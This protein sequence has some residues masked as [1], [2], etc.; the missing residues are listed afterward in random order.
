M[1][2]E[3]KLREYLKRVT[4]DLRRTR[5]RLRD[6]EDEAH[7]PIA[8]VGMACRF[9]GGITSPEALWDLVAASGDAIGGFPTDRGWDLTDLYDPTR[10]RPGTS[11][12]RE[13][14]FVHDAADFDPRFFGISPREALA[15]DPQQR[16]LL[17]VSWEAFESA[18]VDPTGFR[19]GPV[20][21]FAG[22][23]HGGYAT[24]ATDVPD[25]AVDYLGLGNA[26]SISS[27]RVAYSFGFEGPAVTVDTACSSSLVALHLAAQSLRSGECDLALAGGV[28]VLSTPAIFVDF[29]RQGNL[30]M[31]ARCRAFAEAADG[32]A[33]AEGIGVLLVERL[34][35]ARRLGHRVL[36]V[37]RG[38]A[39]NQDG[40]SNGLTA[41]NGPSQ[42]RVIRQA[43]ASARLST[44]DVDVLE[45]HGTG[46]TLGDPI[47]AQALLATYGQGRDGHEPLLLGSVK[48]N[49]GHTQSAA[50]VAGVIKM[51]Q[52][53]R[54]G[55]VPATLHVDEP[56][57]KVDWSAG[58]VTLVTRARQW[59]AVDRPRRAAVSSFGISGTNAHIIIEQPQPQ[60]QPIAGQP[61]VGTA[62]A[63]AAATGLP[64]AADGGQPASVFASVDAPAVG[65]VPGG[66]SRTDDPD[67][68][69]PWLVSG[70]SAEGL[71]GQAAR[72]AEFARR[73]TGTS[74]VEIGWSLATARAALDHRAVLIGTDRDALVATVDALAAG[75]VEQTSAPS[76]PTAGTTLA[77]GQA[78]PGRRALLFAGQGSQRPGMGRELY[79]RFPVFADV[80]DRV[81]G[82]FDGRLDHP[83]REVVFAE[84]G[85]ELAGLLDETAFTQAGLFA[86]EVAL[87]ELLSSFGV[88]A[89]VVAGHSVGEVTAAHVAGVL[90]LEDACAL[91]VARG[92]L[93]QALPP[94]GGMLAVAASEAEIREIVDVDVDAGGVG[95]DVAAV[96][97]PRSVVVSGPVVELDDI[98]QRCVGRG[99]R[100]KRLSVSHA[101]HSRLMEPMLDEFRA[102]L[103]DLEWSSPQLPVV[104]NVSGGI[105][106][107]A[108]ITDP[109]YWVRHVREAVRFGD[110]VAALLEAGVSTFVEVGPDATL[111][112]LAAETSGDRPVHLVAALRRDQSETVGVLTALAR[113]HVTGTS[114]DWASWFTRAG[115]RPR[116]V[117]LPT[118]AFQHQ[119][120][121][122]DAGSSGADATGLGVRGTTH[123]LLDAELVTAAGDVRIHG[124]RLSVR[125]RPWLADHMVWGA[126]VVPGAA[127]VEMALHAGAQA[128]C[129]SLEELTLAAPLVLPEQGARAVQLILAAPDEHGR[130]QLSVHSRPAD[131]P[132][133]EWTRHAEGVLAPG[134]VDPAEPLTTWPPTGA[135]AVPVAPI[136]EHLH[137][138]GVDH[139]P[140]FRGLRA[141]WR[142]DD[143]VY[144]E[145]ALPDGVTPGGFGL[146]P[147][148]LDAA[149]HVV[150]LTDDT[151]TPTPGARLPFAWS[152]VTLAAVGATLLRVR[153][154]R[155]GPAVSLTLADGTG[156]TVAR[157]GS[158]VSR[159][160]SAEQL[161]ATD[162]AE[163][164][165]FDLRW[166]P[167]PLPSRPAVGIVALD[168][169]GL[170]AT[171]LTGGLAALAHALDAGRHDP[172]LVLLPA[173]EAPPGDPLDAT[174]DRLA[175]TLTAVREWLAD[176][177]F[178]DRRLVVFTRGAVGADGAVTDLA[179][180]AVWGLVRSA[181]L[182]HP[183]RFVLVDLDDQADADLL[184]RALASDEPQLALRDGR[185]LVPR[186]APAEPDPT[187]AVDLLPD[188]TVLVT[189]ATGTLGGHVARHLVAAHKVRHLLLVGRRGQDAP[190]AADLLDDLTRLGA[191][192]RFVACDV[193][194]R[195]QVA[196]LLDAVPADHPLT[197]VVHAAGV[198]DDATV[199]A[200]TP[201][202]T[203]TVLRPKA[204]AAWHLHD[205]TRHLD[206]PM[207]VLFSSIAGPLGGPGQGNYAAANAFLDGL[208][209]QRRAAG[210]AATSLAWGVWEADSGMTRDLGAGRRERM[211]RQGIAALGTAQALAL[212]DASRRSRQP[213]L[214]PVRLDL[215]ALR[216]LTTVD[217]LPVPLRG[218]AGN[219]TR[220]TTAGAA[221]DGFRDRIAGASDED[222]RRLVEELVTGQV[223]EVL[224]YAT[225]AAVG[226]GQSF[227]ELGFDS[228]TA[229]DLRNRLT[230]LTGL[231]L[232]ATLVFDHPTPETLTDH[233]V[234]RLGPGRPAPTLL[235]ELDRL[236]A[237]L[238]ATPAEALAELTADEETRSTITARLRALLTRFDGDVTATGVAE[239]IDDASDDE[240]FDF[241]DSTFG[242]S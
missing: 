113:L 194:E 229:V 112:A 163:L 59:P 188:G 162:P 24:G 51:V 67:L 189:G 28:S 149:L 124:G 240:L 71:A 152:G 158:L 184:G 216:T 140:T 170:A 167:L 193:A 157:I 42:Q 36:A 171:A 136:Y 8:I 135:T 65:A 166:S 130:R 91:V 183:G 217:H 62:Q 21:V 57:S 53:M 45:A 39:V 37:V 44:A 225:A 100:A 26:G 32:T 164:P 84:P 138:L 174:R 18:G 111:T 58:A 30:S 9:P 49:I 196:A 185:L 40:A 137:Q 165:L 14:G 122:L 222:R 201:E 177:R 52:A 66:S 101:F 19:G 54:H 74:P 56:S 134:S 43:L 211:A 223:A 64:E 99:W 169:A 23:T 105:A 89:D 16:L 123:A 70:R 47:E 227:T 202:R 93:M 207:F 11:C 143:A 73:E 86:V 46:T 209:H 98:A 81:C 156:A 144:A 33:L 85:S 159:P 17:E 114:V 199:T 234:S 15:M 181:Q 117:D 50:G 4:T 25:G 182:E 75:P 27:G 239:T 1:D 29:T 127:L 147:A 212:F 237:T 142:T 106:D 110:G 208:A 119:R 31:S 219:R 20:G 121:W 153:V 68:P 131:D 168:A 126:V 232:P 118:Y 231:T 10:E 92:S 133:G 102:V 230:T 154:T 115:A 206:L 120:Y 87:F 69:V 94:G 148:L 116:T 220:R 34:S 129:D 35:D 173:G 238:A 224:G 97:G 205:L 172:R 160:V 178:A 236:E 2:T 38:S 96:N 228:L 175:G 145:V 132:D 139:G 233:L 191:Q 155:A 213:L 3:E 242:R 192:A 204:D 88:R 150:G 107:A 215:A 141:A 76:H 60:P 176:D 200:L 77:V 95:V 128:A 82:L 210:L 83:L 108:E 109:E 13:G 180:A 5:Q 125:T 55:V 104:S 187:G 63:A 78:T 61:E 214:L 103:A 90:S 203:A 7:Q 161:D 48:S 186:L 146:H 6:V 72:L 22:L 151:D 241:I 197:G 226:A 198:L 195:D 218:L 41:P 12:V 190:G 80:F 79:E 221:G 235:D 179:G